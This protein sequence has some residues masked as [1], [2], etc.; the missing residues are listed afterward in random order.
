MSCMGGFEETKVSQKAH[1]VAFT[2]DK[3]SNSVK[4]IDTTIMFCGILE[5]VRPINNQ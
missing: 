1:E 5:G 3:N 4:H 2:A